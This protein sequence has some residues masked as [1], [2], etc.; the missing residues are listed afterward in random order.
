MTDILLRLQQSYDY[1]DI[2]REPGVIWDRF[3]SERREAANEIQILRRRLQA[4]GISTAG[5]LVAD[6]KVVRLRA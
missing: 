5:D 1:D 4:A 3:H 6:P 2:D